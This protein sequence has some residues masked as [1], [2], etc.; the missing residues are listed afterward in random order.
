MRNACLVDGVFNTAQSILPRFLNT[1]LPIPYEAN[2]ILLSE[3]LA[4]CA[5]CE[6]CGV[7]LIIE[8]GVAGGRSTEIWAKYSDWP[9]LAVDHC[10]LYGWQRMADTKLRL[11]RHRNIT[12]C[13]GDSW[14]LIPTL[15]GRHKVYNVGLFVDGP[16]G[17]EALALAEMCL[18]KFSHVTIVGIHDMCGDFGD[19]VMSAWTPDVF[20]SDDQRFR[21][22]F[23]FVDG[24][25]NKWLFSDGKEL[26]VKYPDGFVIGISRNHW[27]PDE[28]H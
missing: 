21:R 5:A 27:G 3:G 11:A 7:D 23:A 24:M 25:D 26:R 17:K 8:S 2:G 20:Y 1:V 9:I 4:F 16:K 14:D 10:K 19:H 12:F 18:A 22:R 13:E 6:L 28:S 15:L